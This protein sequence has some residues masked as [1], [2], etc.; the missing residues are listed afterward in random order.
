MMLLYV[1]YFARYGRGKSKSLESC[2]YKIRKHYIRNWEKYYRIS[3]KKSEI[4]YN[5]MNDMMIHHGYTLRAIG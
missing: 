1:Q 2:E 3:A 5:K 4:L